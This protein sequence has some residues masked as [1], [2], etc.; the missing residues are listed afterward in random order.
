MGAQ[1][2][3]R[4]E[5]SALGYQ[6]LE[7]LD[8]VVDAMGRRVRQELP[9]Y[10]GGNLPTADLRRSIHDNLEPVLRSLSASVPLDLGPARATG[11]ERAEQDAP[12]PDVLRAFRLG[13][14]LLWQDLVETARATGLAGDG[15]LVDAATTVWRLAGECTDALAIA[16]RAA[17]TD[18]AVQLEHRR[19]AMLDA[20]FLGTVTDTTSLWEI[21]ETLGL[22]LSGRFLV[23]ITRTPELSARDLDDHLRRHGVRSTWRWQPDA[24]TGLL[25]IGPGTAENAVLADLESGTVSDMG[26]SGLFE[27]LRDTPR[28]LHDAR[29]AL[30]TLSHRGGKVVQYDTSPLAMLVSAAPVEAERISAVVLGELLALGVHERTTLIR[31]LRTWCSNQGSPDRTAEQLHCHPNTIRYRLRRVETL[32]GRSLRDPQHLAELVTA[33]SALNVTPT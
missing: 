11:R 33:L 32:T 25:S 5:L 14:E 16:Y 20:L 12:L 2:Q 13:F 23:A 4:D 24:L 27:H 29:I 31:T 19:L 18:L 28:A 17:S 7:R 26:V 8:A 3:A 9:F 15:S 1:A 6:V 21:G 22:P 30:T 10:A